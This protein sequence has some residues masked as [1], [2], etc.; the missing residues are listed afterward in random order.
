MSYTNLIALLLLIVLVV[1]FFS[2]SFEVRTT[3][4]MDTAAMG[5]AATGDNSM[6][7]ARDAMRGYYNWAVG[8]DDGLE[9]FD[10]STRPYD[11]EYA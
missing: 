1:I 10:G 8:R 7:N 9:A 11:G 6:K 3:R 2:I 4:E 5:C